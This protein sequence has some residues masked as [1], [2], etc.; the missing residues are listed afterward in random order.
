MTCG[1]AVTTSST[2]AAKTTRM[3]VEQDYA[4]QTWMPLFDA[5]STMTGRTMTGRTL[6]VGKAVTYTHPQM[7]ITVGGD[8]PDWIHSTVRSTIGLLS[9]GENWD[10]RGAR[11]VSPRSVEEV[12]RLLHRTAELPLPRPSVVPT[13]DGRIQVEWHTQ[14]VDLEI[15]SLGMDRFRLYFCND[16]EGVETEIDLTSESIAKDM[17]LRLLAQRGF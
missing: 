4:P 10:S 6:Q 11:A 9:L 14:G 12:V 16:A 13:C 1:G 2:T 8:A 17:H 3:R 15:E 7:R 5:G